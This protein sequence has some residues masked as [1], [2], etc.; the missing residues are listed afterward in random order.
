MVVKNG[1]EYHG[2]KRKESPNKNKSKNTTPPK[3][4]SSPLKND[5]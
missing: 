1:D 4:N 5:D 3:F 2:T